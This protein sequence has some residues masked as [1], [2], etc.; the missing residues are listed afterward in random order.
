[1]PG[2]VPGIYVLLNISK[3]DVDAQQPGSAGLRPLEDRKSD[4][5]DLRDKPG[6]DEE[7]II[8]VLLQWSEKIRFIFGQT[9]R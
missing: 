8:S 9:L 7:A 6:H 1:M 2:L 5:S 3:E 4:K